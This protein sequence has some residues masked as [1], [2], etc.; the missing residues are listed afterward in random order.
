MSRSVATLVYEFD[1][2]DDTLM[3]AGKLRQLDQRPLI[4]LTALRPFS[5]AELKSMR[6][7]AER[8]KD[9]QTV[10]VELQAEQ[11]RWSSRGKHRL[12]PGAGHNI[13]FDAPSEVIP[14]VLD[15]TQGW[16]RM[17]AGRH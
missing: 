9:A 15:L 14:R 6:I 1:G 10:W 2:I 17:P 13:Q 3:R 8:G 16:A 5:D 4:V 12:V 7:S 11:A